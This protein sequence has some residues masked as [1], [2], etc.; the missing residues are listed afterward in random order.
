VEARGELR[1]DRTGR[2]GRPACPVSVVQE[3]SRAR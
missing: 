1:L 3:P 2:S